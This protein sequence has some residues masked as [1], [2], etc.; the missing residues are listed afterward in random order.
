MEAA[1]QSAPVSVAP[2][3]YPTVNPR[4]RAL[5]MVILATLFAGSIGAAVFAACLY[6]DFLTRPL[7]GVADFFFTHSALAVAAATSPLFAALLVG[8]GYMQRAMRRRAAERQAAALASGN[9]QPGPNP[10]AAPGA[11]H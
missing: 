6:A 11:L 4:R 5:V 3:D 9:A 2:L 8:Y 1:P 7:Q 10:R